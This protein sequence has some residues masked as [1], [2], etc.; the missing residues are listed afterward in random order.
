MM[1]VKKLNKDKLSARLKILVLLVGSFSGISTVLPAYA[2]AAPVPGASVTANGTAG[3]GLAASDSLGFYNITSFLDT[4]HYSV[5]ASAPGFV[6]TEIDNVSVTAGS[7]TTNVNVLIPVSGGISGK[8]TDAVT[9]APLSGVVVSAMNT[10]NGVVYSSDFTDATGNYQIITNLR[11][12]TYNVTASFAVGHSAKK[13]TG[14]S[15]TAGEMTNNVNIALER[16]GI[17]TGTVTDSVSTAVLEGI[18]VFAVDSNG[19][20][21]STD[22]TNSSGKYTVSMDLATGTYNVTAL[23]PTGHL[24]KTTGGVAVTAGST[25]TVNLALDPSGVISGRIT[26]AANGQPLVGASVTASMPGFEGFA[27]TNDT[28]HY[29]IAE[30]LGTGTYNVTAFYKGGFNLVEGVSVTQGLETSN[31]NLQITLA[32]SGIVSGKVTNS[33]GD[34]V[35]D[36]LVEAESLSGF[37]SDTTDANGIYVIN[38]GLTTDTYNVTVA[39]TGYVSQVKTGINVVL[40]QVTANV[41][42]Q[43]ASKASGRISGQILTDSTPIPEMPGVL[44]LVGILIVTAIAIIVGKVRLLKLRSS[45]PI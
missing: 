35:P 27:L 39:A 41:N 9:S 18:V 43:L 45:K 42:F 24:T 29:R 33:T 19:E 26:N 44:T 31:V 30:R 12:G 32:P 6:N 10:T 7:E 25:T 4:G 21:G 40:N 2:A 15:V 20:H 38:T 17:I 3:F 1:E 11:T 37:G 23:F 36:A 34:P 8:I 14:V 22:V 16:S 28:G 13:A 5:S